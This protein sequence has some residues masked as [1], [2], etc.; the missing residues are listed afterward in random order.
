MA[1]LQNI[2]LQIEKLLLKNIV[3]SV[4]QLR[5]QLSGRSRSSVFRDFRK[6]DLISS[7]THRPVPRTHAHCTV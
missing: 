1:P 6:L 2:P 3:L 5:Q 7:Y 4:K